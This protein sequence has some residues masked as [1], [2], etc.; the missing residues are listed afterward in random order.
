[1]ASFKN[2]T[3]LICLAVLGAVFANS[4]WYQL[5]SIP[6]F[7]FALR[8]WG[9]EVANPW[10]RAVA[11]LVIAFEFLCVLA[12]GFALGTGIT[13]N[14]QLGY[15]GWYAGQAATFA[16]LVFLQGTIVMYTVWNPLICGCGPL[17]LRIDGWLTE[18][19]WGLRLPEP[20]TTS[21][22]PV[23]R[24]VILSGV[25]LGALSRERVKKPGED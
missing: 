22:I 25:A 18:L 16:L 11:R 6:Q 10:G 4:F 2:A 15:N 13:L 19:W 17:A 14:K 24:N 12:I 23:L 8:E 20:E 1:M 3:P 7:V 9:F 21:T 5:T